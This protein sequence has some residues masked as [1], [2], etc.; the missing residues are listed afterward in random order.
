MPIVTQVLQGK[1]DSVSVFGADY[2]TPD[3]TAVR[4]FIHVV[5]LAKAHLAAIRVMLAAAPE[6][7]RNSTYKFV[8]L[9]SF[10]FSLCHPL[11]DLFFPHQSGNKQRHFCPD[12]D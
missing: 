3:G 2:P 1:R 8:F 10:L 7:K 5:D 6:S 4:D 12:C 9:S 11:T